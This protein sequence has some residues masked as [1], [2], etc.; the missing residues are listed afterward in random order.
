MSI[1]KV[2]RASSA[3]LADITPSASELVYDT[4]VNRMFMGDGVTPGGVVIV[5]GS[6]VIDHLA[7]TSV[8]FTQAEISITESQISDLQ[9]YLTTETDPVFT[10]S[11][12]SAI[13]TDQISSWDTANGWG[14][15]SAVGYLTSE[16]DPVFSASPVSAITTDQIANWDTAHT[17]GDHSAAGY[18][19]TESDPVFAAAPAAAITTDQLSNWDAAYTWGDHGTAGYLTSESDPVFTAW[20]KSTGISITES[21]ISDLGPYEP[22]DATLLR[23]GDIIPA[24]DVSG[25]Q[26]FHGFPVPYAVTLS[27]DSATRTVTLTPTGASFDVWVRGARIT[28]TGAQTSPAHA[29]VTANYYLW[30]DAAGDLI[31]STTPWNMAQVSPVVYTYYNA[32][33]GQGLGLFE[34][35]TAERN[36]EWHASQ[37]F[38][39]GT[40][41]RSGFEISGYTLNTSTDAAITPAIASGVI[42][43]EDIEIDISAVADG[44]PYALAYRIGTTS[45]EWSTGA[46]VPFSFT[47][48]GYINYNQNNG[49]TWQLTE[50]GNNQYVNLWLFATSTIDTD[51]RLLWVIGQNAHD[52]LSAAQAESVVGIQWGDFAPSE[53]V[54][55]WR[56]T[57]GTKNT[58]GTTGKVQLA[59]VSRLVGTRAQLSGN[60]SIGSHNALSGRDAADAHPA[61]S[62]TYTPEGSLS[63]ITVQAA[64]T[65]LDSE[66][67]P[68]DSTILKSA[69]IGVT[70]QGQLTAGTNISIVDNTISASST[71]GA[72][73]HGE[74]TGLADDDHT[75]YYNQTRGDARYSLLGH[76]HSGVYQPADADIPTVA[77][78]QAE[79]EAGTETA[80]R[81][82]SPANVK[83][84]IDAL[85]GGG[86]SAGPAFS[87][88][89]SA[90]QSLAASTATKLNFD[91]EVFDTNSCYDTANK[92]FLPNVSGYYLITANISNDASELSCVAMIYVNGAVYLSGPLVQGASASYAFARRGNVVG[93]VYLNGTT[94]YVECYGHMASAGVIAAV[95][96]VTRFQGALIRGA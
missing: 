44:G 64:L 42:V 65:E 32:T 27:Y 28:K 24:T 48:D 80:L 73:D 4:T 72:T 76:D 92:R 55:V 78:S 70:V 56:L 7:D 26:L 46:S 45:W 79:M 20:D 91:T 38:A 16:S 17:W 33:T 60:F 63:A 10:A 94:D 85:G 88:L 83:Q 36:A 12:V 54:G 58:Y 93:L 9:A 39:I 8:H 68:A 13:T 67:E 43:D 86:G 35:H 75:Q 25:A 3:E 66:K 2:P 47:T 87:V 23:Q 59:D 11:P 52:T 81:S 49:G 84:A 1:L 29:D 19:T 74:L 22:A 71:G 41:V 21:Q 50:L 95:A 69:A 40:F 5:T 57:F 96:N 90:N 77:A 89:M 34:L 37:H 30:Y 62:I 18:L 14:D 31:W 53:I 15:H 82:M 61:S 6:E 51:K